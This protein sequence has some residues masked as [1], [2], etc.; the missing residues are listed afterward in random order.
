M[1]GGIVI[2][3]PATANYDED[4]G[5][6]FLNDWDHETVDEL[7][8]AAEVTGPPTL[9]NGLING[10]NVW[11]DS[12]SRFET[13]FTSGTSYRFRVVNAAIDTHWKFSIDNHTFTVIAMDFVSIEPFNSTYLSIGIGQR[14]D[15]VVTADQTADNY[16]MRALPQATCSDND[17]ADNIKGIIRYDSTSTADPTTTEWAALEVDDCDDMPLTDLV[18]YLALDASTAFSVDTELGVTVAEDSADVF[19]WYLNS[20]TFLKEWNDPSLLQIYDND[21]AAFSNTTYDGYVLLP[22]ANVWTALVIETTNTAP[23]PIHLHGHDFFILGQGTGTF[24]SSDTLSTSNPPRRDVAM[25]PGS[26]YLA[27]AWQTDNPGAWLCHCH[28][29]WHTAEGLALQFIERQ[30][31]I[32][33]LIDGD[34]L[35]DTCSAWTTWTNSEDVVQDDSGV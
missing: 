29:G 16:W 33:A 27:I 23:H 13:V 21:T 28:I 26:G 15:I 10:T 4:L 12:G 20:T 2:N 14:Y 34:V 25:L 1:F 18:P 35:N 19:K 8:P 24:N 9:D 7:Y 31:E 6:L 5:S 11:D 17:S 32:T 30:S 3:G 22:D